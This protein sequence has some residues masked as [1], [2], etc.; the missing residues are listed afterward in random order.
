MTVLNLLRKAIIDN[1]PIKLLDTEDKE[2]TDALQVKS[3][4]INGQKFP[5]TEVTNY[6][7]PTSKEFLTL[8]EVYYGF[9]RRDDSHVE[10]IKV[11]RDAKFKA[12]SLFLTLFEVYYGFLRRDDSHVEYI[13]VCRDAKF[14]A[15]SLV[16]KRDLFDYLS[17][18]AAS[19]AHIISEDAKD[20]S[21]TAKAV[22]EDKADAA[23]AKRSAEG[24]SKADNLKKLREDPAVLT[25]Y[26]TFQNRDTIII[27]NKQGK[28]FENVR[29]FAIEAMR[30]KDSAPAASKDGGSSRQRKE[31]KTVD[32]TAG[33][34]QISKSSRDSGRAKQTRR[35][36]P[37]IIV[38][39]VLTSL[40]TLYNVKDFLQE[41]NYIETT[42]KRSQNPEKPER[43][44]LSRKNPTTGVTTIYNVI[45]NVDRLRP[46]DWDNVV[47]VFASGH[48]WQFKKWKWEEPVD[49]F[50]NVKGTRDI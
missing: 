7:D 46:E 45:D 26:K 10:Y 16:H 30:S 29:K 9:L 18:A 50:S 15:V 48:A 20:G 19:S 42:V 47:A 31:E 35:G 1:S 14:K 21:Q 44:Q 34:A 37:I 38:P 5:A 11:C 43:I 3:V 22:N 40:L 25:Q 49:L 36:N 17:G 32:A 41:G 8:F 39:S 33:L 4:D 12:V 27:A 24:L 23:F 28:S 13:K 2:T 6:K